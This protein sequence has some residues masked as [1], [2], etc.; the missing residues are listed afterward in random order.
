M[1][2]ERPGRTE[3]WFPRICPICLKKGFPPIGAERQRVSASL[4]AG[5]T[6]LGERLD[7]LD[8]DFDH[9]AEERVLPV[10]AVDPVD[11]A[12]AGRI[13]PVVAAEADDDVSARPAVDCIAV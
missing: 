1:L 2:R 6:V 4:W 13:D 8:L 12:V 7:V 11:R 5:A 9:V 3:G 10:A